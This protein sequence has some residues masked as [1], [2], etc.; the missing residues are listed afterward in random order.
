MGNDHLR[1][2]AWARIALRDGS[3]KSVR[4]GRDMLVAESDEEFAYYCVALLLT[5]TRYVREQRQ[6]RGGR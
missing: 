1:G 4:P 6:G 5:A 2:C 3:L